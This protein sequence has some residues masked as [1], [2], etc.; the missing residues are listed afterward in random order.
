[1]QRAEADEQLTRLGLHDTLTGLPNRILLRDRIEQATARAAHSDRTVAL[2]LIDLDRFKLLNDALSHEA[3]DRLLLAVAERLR[4]VAGP[5]DTVARLGGDEFALLCESVNDL[6]DVF[7]LATTVGTTLAPPFEIDG[8]EVFVTASIGISAHEGGTATGET[9]LREADAAMYRAKDSGRARY[10][11]Y[12]E[13]LQQRAVQRLETTMALRRA[14]DRDELTIAWQP[15]ISLL[16]SRPGDDPG[17]DLT[18]AALWAEALVRWQHPELGMIG[19]ASFIDL[20]EETGLIVPLGE[21]VMQAACEQLRAWSGAAGPVPSRIS[22]NLSPRQL[23]QPTLVNSVEAVTAAC[24]VLPS[25]VIFEITEY[26]VMNNP[27]AS[28]RRLEELH[29][30]GFG[31]AVD[32]FGTG[33]SSLGYLRRLPVT[34]LKIDQSFIRGIT[35]HAADDA[36]VRGTIELAHALGLTVVAEGVETAEQRDRL[37]EMGCDRAQGYLWSRPVPAADLEALLA[38]ADGR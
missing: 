21:V 15:E 10:E 19:P 11:V 25:Q 37:V 17:D 32:D 9:Y 7:D 4:H 22:I 13:R 33:Y 38:G 6:D 26:A 24:G 30:L 2:L 34:I 23:N 31:V 16:E 36:I 20:A 18:H 8:T 35:Q 12:D 27:E 29:G 3:G 1:V 5:A 14:L 28:V